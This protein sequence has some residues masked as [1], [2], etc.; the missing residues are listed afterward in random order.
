M[1]QGLGLGFGVLRLGFRSWGRNLGL[2]VAQH[3]GFRG[4]RSSF[5]V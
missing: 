2:G 5:G 1:L 4:F 3:L